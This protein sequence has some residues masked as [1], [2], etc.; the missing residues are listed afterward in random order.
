MLDHWEITVEKVS[1][2][3][4]SSVNPVMGNVSLDSLDL[5]LTRK[6]GG[7]YQRGAVHEF[8]HMLG[9]GDEYHKKNPYHRN[10]RSLMN[11]G[12]TLYNRHDIPYMVWL[13]KQLN[14]HGVA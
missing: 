5:T 10:Y 3:A 13:D 11:S 14:N 8:G 9:L 4:V 1:A 12:E 6:K 2:F 7:H